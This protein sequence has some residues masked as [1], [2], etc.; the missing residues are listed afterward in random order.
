MKMGK[1]A[2]NEVIIIMEI[3]TACDCK[4]NCLDLYPYQLH[5]PIFMLIFAPPPK[6][7]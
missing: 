4:L 5:K 7:S 3:V 2:F 1:T 6:N